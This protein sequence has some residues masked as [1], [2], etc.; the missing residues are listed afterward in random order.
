MWW[1]VEVLR[2]EHEKSRVALFLA[3]TVLPLLPTNLQNT[4][5]HVLPTSQKMP[6]PHD[7][8]AHPSL[9]GTCHTTPHI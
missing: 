7:V 9:H 4:S 8:N 2:H 6:L 5:G 1:I 3:G